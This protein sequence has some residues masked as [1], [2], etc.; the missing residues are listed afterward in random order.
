MTI[1]LEINEALLQ[2]AQQLGL[3]HSPEEIITK[4]LEMYVQHHQQLQLLELFGTIEYDEAYDYK[5]QRL[6]G[7]L[8]GLDLAIYS[9]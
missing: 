4:A 1:T 2:Q 5:R 9:E 3:H 8:L 6:V 7:N